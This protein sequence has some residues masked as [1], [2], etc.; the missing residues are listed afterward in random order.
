M[1]QAEHAT[2][3]LGLYADAGNDPFESFENYLEGD[4]LS[5]LDQPE[6]CIILP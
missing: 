2:L 3:G 5:D 4:T 6:Q 1:L